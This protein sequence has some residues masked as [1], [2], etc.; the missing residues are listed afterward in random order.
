MFWEKSP[1]FERKRRTLKGVRENKVIER[2]ITEEEQ[3]AVQK[4]GIERN[5]WVSLGRI[6]RKIRQEDI[7]CIRKLKGAKYVEYVIKEERIRERISIALLLEELDKKRF[8]LV[9]RGHIV[10][11]KYVTGIGKRSVYMEGGEEIPVSRSQMSC[12]KREIERY[13]REGRSRTFQ[14]SRE[15]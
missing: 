1:T 3:E 4:E 13:L 15:K 2:K 5:R 9:D 11:L 6:Y 7:V 14:V 12:L 10:N 8:L